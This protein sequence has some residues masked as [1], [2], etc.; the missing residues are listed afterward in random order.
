MPKNIYLPQN[1]FS[2]NTSSAYSPY[3]LRFS[4]PPGEGASKIG[5]SFSI[6]N[7]IFQYTKRIFQR[8]IE[9]VSGPSIICLCI[10]P[11]L[12]IMYLYIHLMWPYF[13]CNCDTGHNSSRDCLINSPL[14]SIFQFIS[15]LYCSKYQPLHEQKV[16]LVIVHIVIDVTD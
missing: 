9:R 2:S 6:R 12:H 3:Y 15:E 8:I 1:I 10:Q 7:G 5:T 4:M 16:N 13:C 14:I 11:N